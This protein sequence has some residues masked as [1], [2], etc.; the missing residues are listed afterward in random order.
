MNR[1]LSYLLIIFFGLLLYSATV[2]FGF[3]YFDDQSLILENYQIIS[4]PENIGRLFTDD[5]FFSEQ[6]FYFRPL[7][8]LSFMI[9]VQFSGEDAWFFHLANIFFHILAVCL[10]FSVLLFLGSPHIRSLFL[11]FVFLFHPVL[12]QAVAWI[13]GRN[14]SLLA[15]FILGSFLFFLRFLKE[16]RILD[17]FLFL[18]LFLLALFTKEAAIFFPFLLV[19]YYFFITSCKIKKTDKSALALGILAVVFIWLLFR[20]LAIDGSLGSAREIAWAIL[21]FSPATIVAVGK[22]FFPFNLGI[23]PLLHETSIIYGLA[24]ILLLAFLSFQK[25]IK[26]NWLAFGLLWFLLFMLPAFLNP[27]PGKS[28]QLLM[29][30]HRLYLPFIGLVFIFLNFKDYGLKNK[31]LV[32]GAAFIVLLLFAFL[33]ARRLPYYQ[34]PLSFWR[35]AVENSPNSPFAQRNLGAMLYYDGKPEEAEAAYNY[36]LELNPREPMVHNNLGVIYLDRGELEKA[37]KEFLQELEINPGYDKAI[38]NLDNLLILKN[39]LR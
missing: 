11:S 14:D 1:R 24:A 17:Y 37:E 35:Y 39:R 6:N 32:L 34:N 27:D 22:F 38:S 28:Y 16:N 5:A 18:I 7:L 36:S 23:I 30:E 8:N 26:I 29:L 3:S 15:V 10:L 9:D 25:R 21:N 4:Q 20:S 19:F 2:F 12:V 33:S 31:K 13:P